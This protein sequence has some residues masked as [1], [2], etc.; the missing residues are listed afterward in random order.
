MFRNV[1]EYGATGDGQTDDTA[2]INAAIAAGD[3]CGDNADSCTTA[4]ALVYIPRT[5]YHLRRRPDR[6]AGTYKVSAPIVSFYNTHLVGSATD[7]PRILLA[8]EFQGIAAI[9]ENPYRPGGRNW[10]TPQNNF[11][12]GVENL[13]IDLTQMPESTGTGMYVDIGSNAH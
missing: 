1:R 5:C 12:R 13:V 2:A 10:Y 4:P 3:R 8:P 11:F 6:T 7:R 9:D